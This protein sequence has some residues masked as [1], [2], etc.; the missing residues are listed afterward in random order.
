VT[1]LELGGLG[2]TDALFLI[3]I[4]FVVMLLVALVM[5]FSKK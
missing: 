2:F 3:A 1:E 4:W 5:A